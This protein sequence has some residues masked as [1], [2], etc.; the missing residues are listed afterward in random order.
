MR[1]SGFGTAGSEA[2]AR[3]KKITGK[4]RWMTN[5]KFLHSLLVGQ[6]INYPALAVQKRSFGIEG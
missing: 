1:E 4:V 6:G 3:P 5:Y 2:N